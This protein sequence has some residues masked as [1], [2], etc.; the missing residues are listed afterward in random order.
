MTPLEQEILTVVNQIV[1]TIEKAFF[2][3][4]VL[5][6][7]GHANQ[8]HTAIVLERGRPKRV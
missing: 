1:P 4:F 6:H 8:K 7:P 2:D 5:R 3:V